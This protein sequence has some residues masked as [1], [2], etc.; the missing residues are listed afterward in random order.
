MLHKAFNIF[1][2][3]PFCSEFVFN[4]S[5]VPDESPVPQPV[6]HNILTIQDEA[7]DDAQQEERR[8][9][10]DEVK[11]YNIVMRFP[12]QNKLKS[13]CFDEHKVL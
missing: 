7:I 3:W 5:K 6:L 10:V 12:L 8:V 11:D 4:S 13:H 9:K 1:H 2:L